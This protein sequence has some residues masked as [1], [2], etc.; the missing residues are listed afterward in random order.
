MILPAAWENR[1]VPVRLVSI[2]LFQC[3]QRHFFYGSAPGDA[4]VVDEDIDL[5]EFGDRGATTA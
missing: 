2:T 1:N 4:G 3:F 5:P